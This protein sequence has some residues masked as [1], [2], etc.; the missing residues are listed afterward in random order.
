M[1]NE[2]KLI[3]KG[4]HLKMD[5]D[6]M[7]TD[8]DDASVGKMI[9]NA[10]NYLNDRELIDMDKMETMLF[11]HTIRPVLEYNTEKYQKKV[12]HNRYIAS[13]GG[14]KAKIEEP[15]IN[16]MGLIETQNIPSGSTINPKNPKDIV[17]DKSIDKEKVKAKTRLDIEKMKAIL[18]LDMKKIVNQEEIDFTYSVNELVR[19]LTWIR[20]EW[21]VFYVDKKDVE[22]ILDE[23]EQPG[24]LSGILNVK[25]HYSYFLDLLIK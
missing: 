13:K 3:P 16:P 14:R 11:K 20:F 1:N 19:I 23:Y 5:W 15:Q 4:I 24:C 17:K 25:E 8:L 12:E 10:Y 6:D 22:R 18:K 7:I 9:K 2:T 21:L